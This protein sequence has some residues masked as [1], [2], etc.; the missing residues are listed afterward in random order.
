MSDYSLTAFEV[1]MKLITYHEGFRARP[2]KVGTDRWTI[3]YGTT[4]IDKVPVTQMTLPVN[5]QQAREFVSKRIASDF[6]VLNHL[7]P[8]NVTAYELGAILSLS[9]NVGATE[10]LTSTLMSCV[11]DEELIR[12]ACEFPRWSNDNGHIIG[13]LLK[14]RR[15]EMFTFLSGDFIFEVP[16][17]HGFT[18]AN[19]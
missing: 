3:G 4:E 18:T 5:E 8:Y 2:Y 19:N 11:Y 14:R 1:G 15:S 12:A 13:G 6:A 16:N 9:Y 7:F 10:L 17:I